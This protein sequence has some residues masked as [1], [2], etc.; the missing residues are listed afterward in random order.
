L[1]FY[2]D[3]SIAVSLFLRDVHTVSADGW[4]ER[5]EGS[6]ILSDFC[7][8]E[9]AAVISRAVRTGRL[10]SAEAQA[11]LTDFDEWRSKTTV[12]HHVGAADVACAERLVRD[13]ATKLAAADALHLAAAMNAGASLVTFDDR[14]AEAA[15]LQGAGVVRLGR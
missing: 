3:A 15:Q 6:I 9:V 4:I 5:A 7:A 13:F 1:N 2:L 10:S 8:V 14:L 12:P 11:T